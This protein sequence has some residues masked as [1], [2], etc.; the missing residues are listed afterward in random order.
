[1]KPP[2]HLG[3][4][5]G[6][7]ALSAA[8][9]LIGCS[10]G[11]TDPDGIS[12]QAEGGD[13]GTDGE[14]ADDGASG[15]DT[16]GSGDAPTTAAA[17]TVGD[18]GQDTGSDD[19]DAD[20]DAGDDRDDPPGAGA[21]ADCGG[22]SWIGV[23]DPPFGLI[24]SHEMFAGSPG[25]Q[26]GP[27]G[28][29]TAWVDN[30]DPGCDDNAAGTEMAPW[31][32]IPTALSAGDVVEVHGGPYALPIQSTTLSFAGSVEQPAWLRA[33]GDVEIDAGGDNRNWSSQGSYF[34]IEGFTFVG[35]ATLRATGDHFALRHN[36]VDFG[37]RNCI[38]AGGSFGVVFD[39]ELHHCHRQPGPQDAHGVQVGQG[40]ANMWVVGNEIHHNFGNGVQ[41][42]HNAE[43]NP[44][45]LV[46]IAGNTIHHD[47]ETGISSKWS[48][49]AVISCNEIY[50]YAPSPSGVEWCAEDDSYCNT[51][52]SGSAGQAI[53]QGSDGVPDSEWVL[54]N[55]V[56]EANSCF[57]LEEAGRANYVGNVCHDTTGLGIRLEKLGHDTHFV[58]NTLHNIGT[59]GTQ[60]VVQ[61]DWRDDF[62]N[63]HFANNV[64]NAP[65]GLVLWFE[66]FSVV[67]PS[68]I[69]ESNFH[70]DGGDPIELDWHGPQSVASSQELE[71]L[72]ASE[73]ASFAGNEVGDP[74]LVDPEGLDFAPAAGSPLI[75]AATDALANLDAEFRSVFGSDVTLIPSCWA[76]GSFDIGARCAE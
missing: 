6:A 76:D 4:I 27:N 15:G 5:T 60:A 16:G 22:N 72:M 7:I 21:N 50:G 43:A 58:H 63:M 61:Q 48:G 37:A 71:A 54:F 36:E 73:V 28:P 2:R 32:S 42:G 46:Y 57:R 38:N 59:D 10:A 56:H 55:V 11:P 65:G 66:D 68:M 49:R 67:T 39:N 64:F 40:A 45:D 26:D 34:V 19:D 14:G 25:Y 52:E 62:A 13:D 1:M 75:G 53:I 17:D 9:C 29:Y 69:Y 30:T 44:A 33:V 24:E 31:C 35:G 18:D 41:W 3:R 74:Q 12:G 51:P 70:Y 20:D 8:L 47:R 23:P